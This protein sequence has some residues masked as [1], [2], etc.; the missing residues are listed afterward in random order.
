M[1]YCPYDD[2]AAPVLMEC[3][4]LSAAATFHLAGRQDP[5]VKPITAA[6]EVGDRKQTETSRLSDLNDKLA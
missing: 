4:R 1:Y 3:V 6:L 5:I 2:A